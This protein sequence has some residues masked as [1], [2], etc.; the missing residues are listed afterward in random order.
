MPP[1]IT[2]IAEVALIVQDLDRSRR[3]YRA[4]LGLAAHHFPNL[5]QA[6]AEFARVL[7][8]GGILGFAD[9]IT[10]PNKQAAGY[11][12]ALEKLR[13]PAHHWV[14]PLVRLQAMLEDAGPAEPYIFRCG[15]WLLWLVCHSLRLL[16]RLKSRLPQ[17]DS[18]SP[19]SS[20]NRASPGRAAHRSAGHGGALLDGTIR[21]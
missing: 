5:R 14:Y 20:A 1:T 7:K 18:T 15:R 13:D 8:A 19:A 9:K 16:S 11:Y 2:Q 12:N 6:F 4:V 21:A 17:T 3:F 10:V